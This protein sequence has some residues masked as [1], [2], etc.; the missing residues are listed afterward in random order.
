M[1]SVPAQHDFIWPLELNYVSKSYHVRQKHVDDVFRVESPYV[2]TKNVRVSKRPAMPI[3]PVLIYLLANKFAIKV[4]CKLIH[5][6]G[7]V[8]SSQR[9]A[10]KR[11]N[12]IIA[13][14]R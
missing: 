12:L 6:N 13:T 2:I 14:M 11:C 3:A 4:V 5:G 7:K 8:E 9:S 1:R 10:E